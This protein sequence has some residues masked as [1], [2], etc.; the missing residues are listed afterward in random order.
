MFQ[1]EI[2]VQLEAVITQNNVL[3]SFHGLYLGYGYVVKIAKVWNTHFIALQY[4]V[5]MDFM[6]LLVQLLLDHGYT[7]SALDV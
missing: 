2:W 6:N 4:I 7:A 1:F 5:G 3:K